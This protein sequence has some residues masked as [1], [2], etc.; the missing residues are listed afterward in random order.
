MSERDTSPCCPRCGYDQSGEVASWTVSCPV[1]GVC[2]ECGIDFRWRDVLDPRSLGPPWSFEHAKRGWPLAFVRTLLRTLSPGR[3][4]RELKIIH[5]VRTTRLLWL[6]IVP[7]VLHHEALAA[8]VLISQRSTVRWLSDSIP[9]IV[10]WPYGR[11]IVVYGSWTSAPDMLTWWVLPIVPMSLTMLLLGQTFRKARARKAHIFRAAAYA[12]RQAVIL[13]TIVGAAYSAIAWL[14]GSGMVGMVPAT[15]FVPWLLNSGEA[16]LSALYLL[17][18]GWWWWRMTDRYLRLDHALGVAF[19]ALVISG[20]GEVIL[21][22][23]ACPR[24]FA[25]MLFP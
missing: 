11:W 25:M 15:G 22:A 21:Y 18:L 17:W 9:E 12:V 19:A 8:G 1:A 23:Y 14:A 24:E 13:S 2:S 10:A 20:L 6:A 3:L 4:W 16:P 7:I 5:D